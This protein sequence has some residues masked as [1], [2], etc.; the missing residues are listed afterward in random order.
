[1][2]QLLKMHHATS[3][4]LT[5]QQAHA[6]GFELQIPIL[7]GTLCGNIHLFLARIIRF[8]D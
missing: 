3:T 8:G 6:G 7:S 5:C 1:M 4:S 2:A